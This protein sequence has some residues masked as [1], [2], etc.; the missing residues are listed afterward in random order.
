M[1]KNID[2]SA[3]AVRLTNPPEIKE[4]LDKLKV[5]Q[6]EIDTKQ[7]VIDSLIPQSL[8]DEMGNLETEK[9]GLNHEIKLLIDELGSYQDFDNGRYAIKQRRE[10]ISYK[11]ELVKE[12]LPANFAGMVIVESVDTRKMEGMVK[13]GFITPEQAK[14]CGEVIATYAYIIK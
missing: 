8:S 12:K 14:S 11:P 10:S 4:L 1:A 2:Y 7:A 6:S 13:G 9:M 3:S 5:L